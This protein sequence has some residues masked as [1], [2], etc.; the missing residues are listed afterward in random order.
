MSLREAVYQH[1]PEHAFWVPVVLSWVAAWVVA[2]LSVRLGEWMALQPYRRSIAVDPD[3]H[4]TERGRLFAA[5]RSHPRLRV[6][7]VALGCWWT[8]AILEGPLM[9]LTPKQFGFGMVIAGLAGAWSGSWPT[10]RQSLAWS[11][12]WWSRM[13]TRVIRW[14]L[15]H[16]PLAGMLALV[17]FVT[18][19]TR[20][21][22]LVLAGAVVLF[23][24]WISCGGMLWV[25]RAIGMAR[26]PD[27][28]TQELLVQVAQDR[29]VPAPK[30]LR[31]RADFANA[32]A[33]PLARTIVVTD[34]LL[35]VLA[36]ELVRG[37]LAHELAHLRE[38]VGVRLLR[39]VMGLT[40]YFVVIGVPHWIEAD[41]HG[42]L[43]I[44]A[45]LLLLPLLLASL[46]RTWEGQ[47]DRA[48]V[49][50]SVSA[51]QYVQ[52]LEVLYAGSNLPARTRG[53]MKT[54]PDWYDRSIAAGI[55]PNFVRP[56]LPSRS[57]GSLVALTLF[58]GLLLFGYGS[59]VYRDA[60]LL[61]TTVE[62]FESEWPYVATLG[63]P[64]SLITWAEEQW[65]E[66]NEEAASDGARFLLSQPVDPEWLGIPL[67]SI[68]V[69]VDTGH[70][71][72]ARNALLTFPRYPREPLWVSAWL[73]Y[74]HVRCGNI[75]AGR[76]EAER[77]MRAAGLLLREPT[78]QG[79][80]PP[81]AND[82]RRVL[83]EEDFPKFIALVRGL[84]YPKLSRQIE[85]QFRKSTSDPMYNDW[86]DYYL[87]EVE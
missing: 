2:H 50:D 37:L 87:G 56:A 85:E 86:L 41:P 65:Y 69:L 34:R 11:T 84:G 77:V 15:L 70:C 44:A 55:K 64:L 45:G 47:A 57:Q 9:P 53:R 75:D 28:A 80:L 39:F 10:Q 71:R 43:L 58:L 59:K 25:L 60:L 62:T 12:T 26:K 83:P 61:F 5:A 27:A 7:L 20:P 3:L 66:E 30:L 13:R 16:A 48:A 18:A 24:G 40:P 1:F 63:E 42:Q 31:V 33:Y 8:A 32:F 49:Q 79:F 36:P 74:F 82:L 4:W 54:H 78:L 38:G 52:A 67:R 14:A 6:G 68:E 29:G 22:L 23:H 17:P 51:Q 72:D 46:L 76:Q 35:E 81:W 19:E 73:G 21:P